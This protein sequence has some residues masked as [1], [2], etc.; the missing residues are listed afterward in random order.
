MRDN[1]LTGLEQRKVSVIIE[2]KVFTSILCIKL[3]LD[4]KI[5]L[6]YTFVTCPHLIIFASVLKIIL[7]I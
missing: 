5:L 3:A 6:Q 4:L 7:Y 1:V 2:E